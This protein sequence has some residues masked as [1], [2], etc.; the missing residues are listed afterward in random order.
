MPLVGRE[1]DD[2]IS[3]H[4]SIVDEHIEVVRTSVDNS[5][6]AVVVH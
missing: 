5:L 3:V 4:I 1:E 2:L 6:V